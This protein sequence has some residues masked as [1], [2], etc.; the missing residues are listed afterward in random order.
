MPHEDGGI[1]LA[2]C[3][4][5]V[6]GGMG[7]EGDSE[8]PTVIGT[9]ASRLHVLDTSDNFMAVLFDWHVLQGGG[10]WEGR[11]CCQQCWRW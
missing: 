7:W 10:G 11:K 6:G 9:A 3:G 8:L 5:S 1:M 4:G 2:P